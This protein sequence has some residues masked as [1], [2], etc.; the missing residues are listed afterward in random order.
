MHS[1]RGNFTFTCVLY[2]KSSSSLFKENPF[3]YTHLHLLSFTSFNDDLILY[4]PFIILIW[5]Y[6][7]KRNIWYLFALIILSCKIVLQLWQKNLFCAK[8]FLN[9]LQGETMKLRKDAL[10]F[11][12]IAI[13]IC[14]IEELYEEKTKDEHWVLTI[15]IQ[16]R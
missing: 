14:S 15:F 11:T 8:T 16:M 5:K 2:L 4:F 9:A 7:I 13:E 12:H 10:T 6:H 3:K 1:L